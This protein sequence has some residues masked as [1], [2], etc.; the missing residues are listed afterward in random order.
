MNRTASVIDPTD[1]SIAMDNAEIQRIQ[2]IP[3]VSPHL[4]EM[5]F[6]VRKIVRVNN[7]LHEMG[8]VEKLLS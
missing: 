6:D 8:I 2:A 4:M 7:R 5:F 3:I 1:F